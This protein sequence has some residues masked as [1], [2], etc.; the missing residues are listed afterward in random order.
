VVDVLFGFEDNTPRVQVMLGMQRKLQFTWP[1][2]PYRYTKLYEYIPGSGEQ[3]RRGLSTGL[4][5]GRTASVLVNGVKKPGL[6]TTFDVLTLTDTGGAGGW[7]IASTLGDTD[8]YRPI[9][10]S[11][12]MQ[13]F[14]EMV[15]LFNGRYTYTDNPFTTGISSWQLD[16]Y[17]PSDHTDVDFD[18]L[19]SIVQPNKL[20]L[21]KRRGME[22]SLLNVGG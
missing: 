10:P 19:L 4:Q 18:L 17:K 15:F 21:K 8:S 2:E 5:E 22:R 9:L 14:N 16:V 13:V 6:E 11:G 20:P 7:S 12:A 1:T 3:Q